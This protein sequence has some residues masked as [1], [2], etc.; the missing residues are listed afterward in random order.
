MVIKMN[1]LYIKIADSLKA[2]NINEIGEPQVY[3][4]LENGRSIVVTLEQYWL[5]EDEYAILVISVEKGL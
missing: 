1:E 2:G 3:I 4:E 5:P